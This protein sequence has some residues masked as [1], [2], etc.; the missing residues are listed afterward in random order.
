MLAELGPIGIG[1]VL[2]LVFGVAALVV[3]TVVLLSMLVLGTLAAARG[4]L[5]GY[6]VAGA[7]IA[8]LLKWGSRK[9]G[10]ANPLGPLAGTVGSVALAAVAASKAAEKL[11]EKS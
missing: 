8:G 3:G 2:L 1:I 10:G 4:K 11:R 5:W 7:A 6:P 9:N